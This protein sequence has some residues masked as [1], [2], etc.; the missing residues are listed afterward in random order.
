[1]GIIYFNF[2]R[3]ATNIYTGNKSNIKYTVEITFYF[4]NYLGLISL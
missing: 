2:L 4:E 3:F 1:M